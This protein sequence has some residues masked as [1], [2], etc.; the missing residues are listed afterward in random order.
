MPYGCY[1]RSVFEKIGGLDEDLI[2]NQ[3]DEFNFRL[4]QSGGKIWVDPCIKS[5]YF[6]RS[7]FYLLFKQY[8]YYG[9]YKI[10][11]MQKRRG[12]AS[13]RHLVPSFFVLTLI[14]SLLLKNLFIP[15]L[16]C[17]VNIFF[18]VYTTF[19]NNKIKLLGFFILPFIYFN[20]HF[21]YGLGFICGIF[22]FIKDWNKTEVNDT[23]FSL[24][25]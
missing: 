22:R 19:T 13:I 10:R 20:L 5:I 1:K 14:L 4:I 2:R 17:I 6:S 3:D 11:V 25:N 7:S 15:T 9:F 12:I 23:H 16:Y 24:K 18:S 8:F 21:S